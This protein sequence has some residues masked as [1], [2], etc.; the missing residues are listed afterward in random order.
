MNRL[1]SAMTDSRGGDRPLERDVVIRMGDLPVDLTLRADE[2][3]DLNVFTALMRHF[4][5]EMGRLNNHL[6]VHMI[7]PFDYSGWWA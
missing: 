6:R 2:I 7:K 3:T 4:D 1:D 5:L